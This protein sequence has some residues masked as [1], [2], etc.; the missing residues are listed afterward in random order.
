VGRVAGLAK[1][2]RFILLGGAC[3]AGVAGVPL[4]AQR[5]APAN[6]AAAVAPQREGYLLGKG[7]VIEVSVLGRTDYT[8]RVQVQED[9]SVLLPL[10]NSVPAAGRSLLQLREA[11]RAALKKGGYFADPAV[12]IGVVSYASRYVTVLGQVNAPGV[13]P[14]D[15]SYRLS[16]ILARAGGVNS[17]AID[18][19]TLTRPSGES[20]DFVISEIATG[21][22]A[23]DPVVGDGDKLFVAPA[24]TFYIY[25]QVNAPG[26]YPV[27]RDMTLRMALVRG[28]GLTLLGSERRVK[29][30]RGEKESKVKLTE[31][32]Q[33]GDVIVVGE[34]FF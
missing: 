12:N 16:E 27:D 20:T 7:D 22:P 32:V 28:G 26:T 30:I 10:I 1:V 13:V 3:A 34:R 19:V 15:R 8:S 18:T 4:S 9:G 24:K 23:A 14:I 25:G 11:V 17:P 31:R 29:L 5:A 33:P 6:Q 21:G 2:Q